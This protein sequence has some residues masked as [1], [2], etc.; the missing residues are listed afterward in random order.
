MGNTRR[1]EE[2]SQEH[3]QEKVKR[4]RKIHELHAKKVEA[5]EVAELKNFARGL[6]KRL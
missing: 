1:L 5:Q 4:Y 3:H 2:V 6:Q